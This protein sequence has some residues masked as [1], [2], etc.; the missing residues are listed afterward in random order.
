MPNL[1]ILGCDGA[2][3]TQFQTDHGQWLSTISVVEKADRSSS[4]QREARAADA[5]RHEAQVV[6]KALAAHR[7]LG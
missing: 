4:W 3:A 2:P 1:I 6:R 5:L 7:A